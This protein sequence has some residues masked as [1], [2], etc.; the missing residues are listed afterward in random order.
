[1]SRKRNSYL[2]ANNIMRFFSLLVV[3]MTAGIISTMATAKEPER[4]LELL[5]LAEES[6]DGQ[7]ELMKFKIQRYNACLRALKAAKQLHDVGKLGSLDFLDSSNELVDSSLNLR[8]DPMDRIWLLEMHVAF[9][10]ALHD[11]IVNGPFLGERRS[12]YLIART[13]ARLLDAKAKLLAA[14]EQAKEEK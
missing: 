8:S 2:W 4:E 5:R 11:N 13:E 9:I 12:V 14:K 1:M 10:D 7:P 3:I 6:A